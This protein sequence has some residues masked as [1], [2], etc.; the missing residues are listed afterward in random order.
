M[1]YPLYEYEPPAKGPARLVEKSFAL[2]VGQA[3]IRGRMDAIFVDED[4]TF[5]LIDWKTGHPRQS[6]AER[7]Q[8]PLYALAAHRLWGVEEHR[9]RLAYAFA[10]GGETVEVDTSE[11]FLARAEMRALT[12][13]ERIRRRDF[14]PQPSR[15]ACSHCPV[16][17]LGLEG[18]PEEV[19]EK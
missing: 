8:L 16:M 13:I 3:G 7:L 9:I 10:P 17:G 1:K 11:G 19:P 14:E 2:E 15:Y 4:G 12:A 5:H 6:Y 18:C